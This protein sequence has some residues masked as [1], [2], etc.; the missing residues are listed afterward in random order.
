MNKS[1]S[2]LYFPPIGFSVYPP[3]S[4]KKPYKPPFAT[5]HSTILSYLS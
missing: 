2:Y 4:I 3:T 5:R 1:K